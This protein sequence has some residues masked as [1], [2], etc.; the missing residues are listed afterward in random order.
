MA[1][2]TGKTYTSLRIAENQV[3]ENGLVLFL[4]PSIA[5]LGQTLREWSTFAKNPINAICI[6]SDP[7]ISKKK[8]K[9]EDGSVKATVKMVKIIDGE[10]M[11]V[12]KFFEGTEAEVDAKIA[13]VYRASLQEIAFTKP[14]NEAKYNE[15]KVK[16][17]ALNTPAIE[18]IL[19]DVT[20]YT[21]DDD[22][23]IYDEHK[24]DDDYI[25]DDHTTGYDREMYE[26]DD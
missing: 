8:T 26:Y 18:R 5:L 1:C 14:F 7:E 9:N 21:F 3:G 19:F 12:E 16:I 4:V 6:C 25:Y 24:S 11:T 13:D 2:G 10:E 22:F 23:H 15:L 17:L 20:L